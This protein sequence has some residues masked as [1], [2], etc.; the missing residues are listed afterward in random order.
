MKKIKLLTLEGCG[1]CTKLKSSLTAAG[2]KY[3]ETVCGRHNQFCDEIENITKCEWYPMVI[4]N[5]SLIV[6]LTDE[7]SMIDQ[8]KKI[9]N[10][11]QV[12]YKHSIDSLFDFI[13][14]Y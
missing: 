5:D 9:S 14:K 4:M 3:D 7:Y 13:K 1:V 6:C 10:A 12:L 2:L 11:T 8:H